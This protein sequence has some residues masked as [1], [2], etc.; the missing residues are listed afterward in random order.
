MNFRSASV[1]SLPRAQCD[2]LLYCSDSHG[3]ST[4][5]GVAHS[6]GLCTL[7]AIHSQF[8]ARTVSTKGAHQVAAAVQVATG[9][10]T[11]SRVCSGTAF[12]SCVISCNFSAARYILMVV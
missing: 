5:S 4:H 10:T 2:V 11:L 9:L 6:G 3:D 7:G 1:K 8:E 12:P